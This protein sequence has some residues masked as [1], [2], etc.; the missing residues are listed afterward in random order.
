MKKLS[1]VSTVC[2]LGA[3]VHCGSAAP[4]DQGQTSEADEAPLA[5]G[6]G[7]LTVT[8]PVNDSTVS[9]PVAVQAHTTGCDDAAPVSFG[10]SVDDMTT[11][12]RGDTATDIDTVDSTIP[13]GAHTIHFKAWTD[14]GICPVV[15]VAFT[16]AASGGG[17]IPAD[18]TAWSG[19][20]GASNWVFVH[21]K[22]TPGSSTGETEY[23]VS[24]PGLDGKAR[25]FSLTYED[26]GGERGSLDFAHHQTT[27]THF[28]YDTYVY[29]PVPSEVE[30]VEMDMNQ[31][32][33]NG[34]TVI[35]GTQ[36]ASG[37]GT[38]EFTTVSEVDGKLGTHWHPS[39]LACDPKSWTANT[40]HH[41]E[42]ASHR[43]SANVV[44]YDWVTF[45]GT[46]KTFE[47]ASGG[48]AESLGWTA[49]DLLLNFQ[50]DGPSASGSIT[51]Y[52]DEM[53]V[54]GW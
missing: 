24:D 40:W 20:A 34:D 50:L 1:A 23:P 11:L 35:F 10:Y 53:T 26:H 47:G 42:I 52:I 19:L 9:S 29:L 43:D 37:S 4:S 12:V 41:I 32:V 36:C 25:K 31:V 18:A 16:V 21:D 15:D 46:T 5:K 44:T 38:W 28:V 45:D 27:P 17:T 51:A 54:Y 49:G 39:N 8:S 14:K 22:G 2:F 7:V 13:V 3:L 6:A 33:S 48:S 30:N